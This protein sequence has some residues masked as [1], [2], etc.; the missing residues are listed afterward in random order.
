[1]KRLEWVITLKTKNPNPTTVNRNTNCILCGDCSPPP[2]K[3]LYTWRQNWILVIY[4]QL[5]WA[6][7]I[8]FIFWEESMMSDCH[9]QRIIFIWWIKSINRRQKYLELGKSLLSQHKHIDWEIQSFLTPKDLLYSSIENLLDL[10]SL[11]FRQSVDLVMQKFREISRF[12]LQNW[13]EDVLLPI[14]NNLPASLLS[15]TSHLFVK[16]EVRTLIRQL[17]LAFDEGFTDRVEEGVLLFVSPDT[18]TEQ[19]ALCS[20]AVHVLEEF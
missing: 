5:R 12:V 17:N 11:M 9:H 18:H 7:F 15:Q 1:M 14:Q 8:Y 20:M 16:M 3:I 19:T 2:K 6:T 4:P 10:V 13:E